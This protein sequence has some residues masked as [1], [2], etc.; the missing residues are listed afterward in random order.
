MANL[1]ATVG[2]SFV[3]RSGSMTLGID[4][5]WIP[6]MRDRLGRFVE[7]VRDFMPLW[8]DV[9]E[10]FWDDIQRNIDGEGSY[11]GGWRALSPAYARWKRAHVGH[12]RI[13]ILTGRLKDSVRLGG[14]NNITTMRSNALLLG[15]RD[16]KLPYHQ[17]GT[18]RMPRRPIIF[19]SGDPAFGRLLRSFVS[20]KA[21]EAG[22]PGVQPATRSIRK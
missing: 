14:R 13:M 20:S 12:T 19:W 7:K 10:Q 16:P 3:G 2:T 9:A 5:S 8:P 4:A 21:L 1:I 17:R 22:L 18:N 15:S 6:Q 11:V